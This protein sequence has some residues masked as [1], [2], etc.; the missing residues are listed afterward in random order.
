MPVNAVHTAGLSDLLGVSISR[1]VWAHRTG[2]LPEPGRIGPHRAYGPED[3]EQA[4][5]YFRV[6]DARRNASRPGKAWTED[7][8]VV[9]AR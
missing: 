9:N 1:I 6:L 7:L 8:E 4:R 2:K 5:N 3:V